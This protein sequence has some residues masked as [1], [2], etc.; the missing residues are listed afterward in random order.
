[1]VF[2]GVAD[3]SSTDECDELLVLSRERLVA[4]S[5][6]CIELVERDLA[7]FDHVFADE[8]EDKVGNPWIVTLQAQEVPFPHVSVV[9]A[10]VE[11]G[12]DEPL[13]VVEVARCIVGR[14]G[15]VEPAEEFDPLA[16]DGDLRTIDPFETKA[17]RHGGQDGIDVRFKPGWK[18]R[19]QNRDE[20]GLDRHVASM[21]EAR[22]APSGVMLPFSARCCAASALDTRRPARGP[23]GSRLSRKLSRLVCP[24]R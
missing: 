18:D 12:Q 6:D 8:L 22:C 7:D 13:P 20:N 24:G 21:A 4:G 15:R 14:L 9:M 16:L 5:W 23:G 17:R 3:D 11:A 1:V 10:G 2:A 19:P